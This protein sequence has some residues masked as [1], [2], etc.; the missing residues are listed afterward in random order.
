MGINMLGT[1]SQNS[2]IP[3]VP[4]PGPVTVDG[5]LKEWDLSG[6]IESFG[7]LRTRSEYSVQTA[8]MWDE[9]NLYIALIWRDPTPLHNEI[10][11][12]YDPTDGWKGDAVQ[13]RV[14]TDHPLWIT[15]WYYSGEKTANLLLERWKNPNK[16]REGMNG[17]SYFGKPGNAELGDGVAMAFSRTSDGY[18][19]EIRIPWRL[20]FHE[21]PRLQAG[22]KI[23]IGFEFVWGNVTGKGVPISR[24]AD[25]MQP[26]K[27]K[28]LFFYF[29]KDVWGDAELMAHGHLPLREYQPAKTGAEGVVTAK[30]TIPKEAAKF[31]LVIEDEQNRRVRNL[32]ADRNPRDFAKQQDQDYQIEVG[33]DARDDAGNL[34]K[35]GRYKVRGLWH[36]GLDATYDAAFYNPGTPPW[37]TFD[38]TGSWGSNHVEPKYVATAGD[39]VIISWHFSEGGSATIGV[40]PEGRK[41]WGELRG[42]DPLAA[43]G[44]VVY[45]C[46]KPDRP[47]D[48]E[49]LFRLSAKDGH[50]LPFQDGA[51]ELQFPLPLEHVLGEKKRGIIVA[52]A[53]QGG[54]LAIAL[55]SGEVLILDGKTAKVRS[56][57]ST[58]KKITALAYRTEGE[59]VAIADGV[60]GLY[61]EGQ[62]FSA[63]ATPGLELAAAL[64]IDR[65]GHVLVFD[66][67]PD[68]QVKAYARDGKL[69]Y[70]V[71]QKGGR[72]VRGKFEPGAL[73]SVTSITVDHQGQIWAVEH[74]RYPRRVSVWNRQGELVRDYI[75]GTG[76][77]AVGGYFAEDP[78]IAYMGPME[79]GLDRSKGS[80]AVN[81]IL[82][83]AEEGRSDEPEKFDID[84]LLNN[85][86]RRF[87]ST[88]GGVEREFL[89]KAPGYI[90]AEPSVLFMEDD[91]KSW[92]PVAAV[93]LVGQISG[94]VGFKGEKILKEPTGEFQG[95]SAWDGFFWNDK[96]EDGRVQRS[97]CEIVPSEPLKKGALRPQTPIIPVGSGW[98]TA[99]DPTTLSFYTQGIYRYRPLGFTNKGAPVYGPASC[100]SVV[101][102]AKQ[103]LVPM[104]IPGEDTIIGLQCTGFTKNPAAA[105]AGI[106]GR[107]GETLWTYPNRFPGVHGSHL[108]PM[109]EP[110]LIIG[111]L[112]IMGVAKVTDDIGNVFAIRGNLGEDYFFT[113]DGLNIGALFHDRRYPTKPMPNTVTEIQDQSVAYLSEGGEPFSGWF[114]KLKDGSIRMNSS[115]SHFASVVVKLSGLETVRRFTGEALSVTEADIEKSAAEKK[116]SEDLADSKPKPYRIVKNNALQSKPFDSASWSGVPSVTIAKDGF[117]E[118]ALAQLAYDEK[119]LYV[120]FSVVDAT[121]MANRGKNPLRLFKSGDAVDVQLGAVTSDNRKDPVK[122]DQRVLLSFFNEK[123]VAVIMRPIDPEAPTKLSESYSSPVGTRQFARVEQLFLEHI[124]SSKTD[125]GYQI[126]AAIPWESLA[127]QPLAGTHLMGDLGFISSDATGAFNIARTYWSNKQTGLVNDEPLEAWIFP[128]TWGEFIL[129]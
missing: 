124:A 96:N 83:K 97:E 106:D 81:R 3:V 56:R 17:T 119:N 11:P 100:E 60:V 117:P 75:G 128:R 88:A 40:G 73:N 35:P 66:G 122:N 125:D 41:I 52:M 111:P 51:E 9:E 110:G 28:R 94:D 37:E 72:P 10:D 49:K 105:F 91:D 44:D 77:K 19:Q 103:D 5:D 98:N 45:G 8:A 95:L 38:G 34:V 126:T 85:M 25:N 68:Q 115:L 57:I 6:R 47:E 76:Y 79:I 20:L 112:K 12:K 107:T 101:D 42:A 46:V 55:E 114:G 23:Q 2:G 43:D 54:A 86:A 30:A 1:Q 69:V 59:L 70:T 15:A 120:R 127:I 24:Y 33:W 82:W 87:R 90:Y 80:F 121:P 26:G 116:P 61:G 65:D 4:A 78:N 63:L 71:G 29:S 62:K 92:R 109:P 129:E 84:P 50:Y 99:I 67:G 118:R 32:V 123:P 39:R 13:F 18:T 14:V 104:P 22:S 74:T 58:G 53:A 7:E 31:T 93:G 36:R 21:K 108:A 113:A 16:V 102:V 64:A 89:F 48:G 27:T